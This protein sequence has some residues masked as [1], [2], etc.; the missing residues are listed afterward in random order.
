[1]PPPRQTRWKCGWKCASIS[2]APVEQD[3]PALTLWV[4]VRERETNAAVDVTVD[5]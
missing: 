4:R 1:V 5:R 3:G 2:Y